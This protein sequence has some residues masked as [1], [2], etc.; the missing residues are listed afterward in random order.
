MGI[1][2]IAVERRL[3]DIDVNGHVNN[4]AYHDYLQEARFRLLAGLGRERVGQ[5]ALVVVRQ[6]VD[7][8]RPLP[9]AAAPVLVDQWVESVGRSSFVIAA[10]MR[11]S[12][13]TIVAR[14]RTVM[15]VFD[16]TTERSVPMPD[17]LREGLEAELLPEGERP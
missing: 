15:V 6:E 1:H 9:M 16:A 7:H 2:R 13:E 11:D 17:A 12:D 14:A 8:L 4:V 5:P 10:V 3:S